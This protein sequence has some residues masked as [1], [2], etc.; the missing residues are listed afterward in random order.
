MYRTEWNTMTL[1]QA[2]KLMEEIKVEALEIVGR[3]REDIKQSTI[4]E[5]SDFYHICSGFRKKTYNK[6]V[7]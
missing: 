5:L 2:N 6:K 1:N 4:F 7:L 3:M